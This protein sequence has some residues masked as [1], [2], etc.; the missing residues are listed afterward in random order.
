MMN[1]QFY[2]NNSVHNQQILWSQPLH[3][4]WLFWNNTVNDESKST[5]YHYLLSRTYDSLICMIISS[6]LGDIT[7]LNTCELLSAGSS[8]KDKCRNKPI[9]CSDK[10]ETRCERALCQRI[11]LISCLSSW[12][13]KSGIQL[14][15]YSITCTTTDTTIYCSPFL[16]KY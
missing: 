10:Q 12:L 2:L 13:A 6:T 1:W 7:G 8:L 16:L 9:F 4:P 15:R 11:C 3:R 5:N 14:Y